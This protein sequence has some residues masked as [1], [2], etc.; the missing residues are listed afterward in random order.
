MTVTNTL[1]EHIFDFDDIDTSTAEA[2]EFE[3][4]IRVRRL[5]RHYE[6]LNIRY[7]QCIEKINTRK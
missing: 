3:N 6:E 1:A 2:E 7:D 5:V 4:S